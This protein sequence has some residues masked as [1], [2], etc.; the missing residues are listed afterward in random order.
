MPAAVRSRARRRMGPSAIDL[1]MPQQLRVGCHPDPKSMSVLLAIS[2]RSRS[3]GLPPRASQPFLARRALSVA[4]WMSV[5]GVPV[6][7][8]GENRGGAW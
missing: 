8:G 7:R 3:A 2:G 5:R 1:G 6:R 4:L